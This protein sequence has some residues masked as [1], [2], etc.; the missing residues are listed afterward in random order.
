MQSP[1]KIHNEHIVFYSK[2]PETVEALFPHAKTAPFDAE[3]HLCAVPHTLDACKLFTNMGQKINGPIT[4]SYSW[5]GLHRPYPHQEVTA[6]F[7]TLN[8]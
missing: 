8:P 1:I 3:R 2:K 6:N 5:P 4:T 7:L